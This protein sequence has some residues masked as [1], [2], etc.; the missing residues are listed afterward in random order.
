MTDDVFREL[1]RLTAL[2]ERFADEGQMNLSKL[3]EAAVYA[4]IRRAGWE[5]RPKITKGSMQAELASAIQ[6]LKQNGPAPELV[7]AMETGL[8][9]LQSERGDDMLREEAPDVFVCRACGH[10]ALGQPPDHCPDCGAWPG[11]SRKFVVIF[12]G[13]N[14]EPL[15]PMETLDLLAENADDLARL[16]AGLSEETMNRGPAGGGWSIR[17]HIAHFFD[18]QELLDTRVELMLTYDDPNLASVAVYEFATEVDRHPLTA[19][20]ILEEYRQK[21]AASVARLRERP[22]PDLYRTGQHPEFGELT[23]LRQ[24][25][26]MAFHEQA[27]LPEIEALRWDD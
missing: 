19:R 18:T 27:H 16:V 17:E 12:N 22:L 24:A 23:I 8:R 14:F 9:G 21:R 6:T 10:T 3:A 2:A 26:Y 15:N 1:A 20:G 5:Y 11:R 13:D 25:A 7:A 4:Q